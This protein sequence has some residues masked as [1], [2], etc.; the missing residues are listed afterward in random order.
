MKFSKYLLLTLSLVATS[1]IAQTS[2]TQTWFKVTSESSSIAVTL[3]AGTTYRFGD[4]VHNKWSQPVMVSVATTFSPVYYPSGVFPFS[5]PDPG[6][7]KELDV[8]EIPG[9]QTISVT[10]LGVSPATTA[11]LAIPS[12]PVPVT[13]TPGWYTIA[14][15]S[16][17]TAVT[18]PAGSTY[19]LGDYTNNKWSSPVTV[20]QNTTFSPLYFPSGQFPFTDPDPGTAK[21]LDIQQ[22]TSTQTVSVTNLGTSPA[23]I[24]SL[25]VP[26]LTPPGSIQTTPGTSYTITF[27]NFTIPQGTPQDA[28]MLALVNQPGTGGGQTW[29]GTQMNLN[30]GGVTLVCTYGPTYT[31]GVFTMNCS[32][33]STTTTAATGN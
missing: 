29:E 18:I 27:S 17:T 23:T 32:V 2:T 12:L 19:R 14:Q 3:P 16:Q 26:A 31:D 33:P 13:T 28:L 15:E 8:L 1:A 6:T 10:N 7:A 24:A 9:A 30:I 21:E 4:P 5:D 22:T 11:S 25:N 20:S